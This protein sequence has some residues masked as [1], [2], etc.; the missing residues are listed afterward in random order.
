M[1][2]VMGEAKFVVHMDHGSLDL[3][4]QSGLLVLVF[5]ERVF[6]NLLGKEKAKAA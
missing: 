1:I 6:L 4:R 2:L 5:M 3:E